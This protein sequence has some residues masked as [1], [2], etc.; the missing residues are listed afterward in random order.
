MCPAS[1]PCLPSLVPCG[2]FHLL[3]GTVHYPSA[4]VFPLASVVP[5]QSP[6]VEWLALILKKI[7]LQGDLNPVTLICRKNSLNW[8]TPWCCTKSQ[9]GEINGQLHYREKNQTTAQYHFELLSR[10]IYPFTCTKYYS[11]WGRNKGSDS[12]ELGIPQVLWESLNAIS[13]SVIREKKSPSASDW[14]M[15]GVVSCFSN[16]S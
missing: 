12:W 15:M 5:R 14:Q 7:H 16:S 1:P 10:R 3:S 11:W 9:F 4:P 6:P 13:Y 2:T 8:L